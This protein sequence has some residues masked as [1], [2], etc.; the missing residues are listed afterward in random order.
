MLEKN[1]EMTA[2]EFCES[3]HSLFMAGL[4]VITD[5]KKS[6]KAM[7]KLQKELKTKIPAVIVWELLC[8]IDGYDPGE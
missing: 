6:P 8:E 3:T 1:N 2:T 5:I 4:L 7:K